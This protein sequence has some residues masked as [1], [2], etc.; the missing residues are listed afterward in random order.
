MESQDGGAPR[1]MVPAMLALWTAFLGLAVWAFVYTTRVAPQYRNLYEGLGDRLP[2]LTRFFLES[3]LPKIA[4]LGV[5]LMALAAG[6]AWR[7]RR[8]AGLLMLA[9]FVALGV[10]WMATYRHALRLPMEQA[11]ETLKDLR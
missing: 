5:P 8:G 1:W 7:L 3:P 2:S 6:A 4:F 9:F 10:A 11:E